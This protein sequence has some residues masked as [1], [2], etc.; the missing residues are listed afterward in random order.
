[1]CERTARFGGGAWGSRLLI[2][3]GK[4]E[5]GG[6]R[7]AAGPAQPALA[8]GGGGMSPVRRDGSGIL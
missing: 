3:L 2:F 1:M 5:S 7:R 4:M 6:G 8:E